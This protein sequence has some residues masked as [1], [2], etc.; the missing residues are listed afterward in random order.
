MTAPP[1]KHGPDQTDEQRKARHGCGGGAA[2]ARRSGS[3][4]KCSG[5]IAA[6]LFAVRPTCKDRVVAGHHLPLH[7]PSKRQVVN[8]F[9]RTSSAGDRTARRRVHAHRFD[10]SKPPYRP[11][12]PQFI[13]LAAKVQPDFDNLRTASAVCRGKLKN[14][15]LPC[16]RFPVI[17]DPCPPTN[18]VCDHEL[19]GADQPVG[20]L[21]MRVHRA[22]RAA[23]DETLRPHGF[24]LPQVT[25]MFALAHKSGLSTADLARRAFVT[26]QAMGEVLA[27]LEAKGC[28]IRRAH[29]SHGRILPAELTRGGHRGAKAV[30]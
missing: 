20:Y 3:K 21:L 14:R 13:Q 18:P 12:Q 25:V 1:A 29:D 24:T 6:A 5:P 23:I 19:T 27:G 9:L 4:S 30:P 8:S 17:I 7:C 15:R 28:V 26:P 22:L 16:N 10:V 2:S 11:V